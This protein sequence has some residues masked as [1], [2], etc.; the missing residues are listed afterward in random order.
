MFEATTLLVS[1][2]L[3][4][5]KTVKGVHDTIGHLQFSVS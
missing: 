4:L 2:D 1:R 3:N 5:T